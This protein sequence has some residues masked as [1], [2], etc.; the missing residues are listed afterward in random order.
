MAP[1]SHWQEP[2]WHVLLGFAVV[3]HM[4]PQDPQFEFVL[5]AV[6]LPLQPL[7]PEAQQIFPPELLFTQVRAGLVVHWTLEVQAP[8]ETRATHSPPEQ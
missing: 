2:L 7:R 1:Y 6:Q 8:E 4:T 5:R 3:P